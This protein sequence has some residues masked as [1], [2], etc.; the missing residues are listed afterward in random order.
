MK[1]LVLL[2]AVALGCRASAS[3]DPAD[4]TDGDD[5]GTAG[6]GGGDGG[7]SDDTDGGG[8]PAEC[9]VAEPAPLRR[10]TPTE[11]RNTV[12]DLLGVDS[13][14][15]VADFPI[16][17]T[18]SG[19]DNNA[20]VQAFQLGHA[21]AYQSA[22][23]EIAERLLADP[24]LRDAVVGC[25]PAAPGDAC[26]RELI[27]HLAS[28]AYR[29]PVDASV[30]DA[31][32]AIA[33]TAP[34]DDPWASVGLVVRAVLQSPRFL[35]RVERSGGA[36]GN[37]SLQ[38]LDGYEVATRLSYLLW[39]ST[40]DAWLLQRAEDGALDET[41]GVA[42]VVRQMLEREAVDEALGAF[43]HG[44][45]R[46]SMLDDLGRDPQLFPEWTPS[47]R[48][49]M[50]AEAM[51]LVR[52]TARGDGLMAAYTLPRAWID[53]ELAAVYGLPAPG[54]DDPTPVEL[55]G[56]AD[57]GG[58]LTTAAVLALT[59]PTS[60][61][62]PVRRGVYVWD[63]LL[64][65]PLPPPP[66]GAIGELP[67]PADVPKQQALEQHRSDPACSGCHDL[68]DPIGLG[69]ERYDAIGR[70]RAVDEGGYPIV[71]EGF[72]P[73]LDDGS[74]GGGVELG[75]RLR[76]MPD[77]QRCVATQVFRWAM[78]RSETPEDACVLDALTEVV[79]Q[80][81]GDYGEIIAALAVSDTFRLRP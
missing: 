15:L 70:V 50:R 51:A 54:S 21:R 75:E 65:S 16:D 67:A 38:A 31:L 77:A 72:V 18:V 48:E 58:L 27:E 55:D 43:A 74:F 53:D 33:E 41:D 78:G 17:A 40:P 3:G 47:L 68:L 8:E 4:G 35:F 11:Y 2:C 9:E 52:D 26:V 73:G 29:R 14:D 60:I 57:R 36:S 20:A 30:V 45:L 81:N 61:T 37:G 80:T 76:A 42:E 56:T 32:A 44:W 6:E 13:S 7:G 25:T 5:A 69:L 34:P 39:Q 24:S 28:L 63:A 64:C 79:A 23:E 71:Q 10:L 62:S 22:A 66:P 59:T 49:A 12:R 46:L 1:R 19:F